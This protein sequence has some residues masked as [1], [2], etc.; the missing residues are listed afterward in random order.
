MIERTFDSGAQNE[1][2]ALAWTRTALALLLA[3]VLA[4]RL[5]AEPLGVLAVA[6]GAVTAPLAVLVLLMA[7]RRYR[8]AHDALHGERA[9]PD[10]RLPALVTLITGLLAVLEIVYAVIG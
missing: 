10:G 2:T 8:R 9:L 6:F 5:A 1:R 3:A 7:R 4:T